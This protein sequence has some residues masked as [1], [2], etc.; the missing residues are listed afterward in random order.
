[1]VKVPHGDRHGDF[2]IDVLLLLIALLAVLLLIRF[3]LFAAV[4]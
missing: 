1:M 4:L 2:D 3:L